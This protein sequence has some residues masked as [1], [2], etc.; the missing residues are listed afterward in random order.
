MSKPMT[1]EER[2]Q[3]VCWHYVS[4]T[5]SEMHDVILRHITEA[6]DQARR[7]ENEACAKLVESAFAINLAR[8]IRAR[9]A[10]P[11]PVWCEHIEWRELPVS[12]H[13][14]WYYVD[15]IVPSGWDI[16]PVAGCHK[17]RPQVKP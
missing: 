12:G 15:N 14:A 16:C 5:W 2:W 13:F 6:A 8:V 11:K 1:P 7:E 10:P 3:D 4:K 17:P 9:I